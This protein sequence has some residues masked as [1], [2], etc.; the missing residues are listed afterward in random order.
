MFIINGWVEVQIV[1][2]TGRGEPYSR[3][4]IAATYGLLIQLSSLIWNAL[5]IPGFST[6][7]NVVVSIRLASQLRHCLGLDELHVSQEEWHGQVPQEVCVMRRTKM[8]NIKYF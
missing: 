5:L 1:L 2:S 8:R 6:H 3:T 4:E 7:S